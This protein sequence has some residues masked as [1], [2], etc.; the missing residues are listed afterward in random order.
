[1]K[2]DIFTDGA[3]TRNGQ[4]GA[5]ASWACWFP[6][7]TR[8]SKADRIPDSELQTNQRGELTAINQAVKIAETNFSTMLQE[9]D[10]KIY[11]DSTYSKNCLTTWLPNWI[12][13]DW[14]NSQS[15]PVAH[16]DL[17]EDTSNRLSRFKSFAITYVKAHTGGDDYNSK[18]NH[19]VDRM[20]VRVIEPELDE[21]IIIKSNKETPIEGLPLQLMGPPISENELINWCMNNSTKLDRDSLENALL[22][23]LSKTVKKKG[24]EMVKQRLHRNNLYRLK[25]DSGLIKEKVTI[26]KEE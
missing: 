10:L 19:I 23:A 8:L 11:T 26:T 9:I 13:N 2:I 7:H 5:K 17:I 6:E 20:A 14:K 22:S 25:T 4:S 12:R 24:F 18:N 16:K 21:P 15:Q 3:C 1:M